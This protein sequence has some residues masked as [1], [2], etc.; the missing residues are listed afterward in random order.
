MNDMSGFP[1]PEQLGFGLYLAP[2]VVSATHDG[3]SWS[4]PA[5]LRRD[6]ARLP[7]CNGAVQYG[8][9]VFEGLKAYRLPD[10]SAALFRPADHAQR[11]AASAPRLALPEV[12]DALFLE[13]C[14]LAV[15]AHDALLPPPGRGSLYLR[16]TICADDETLGL[17]RAE[18]HR[19]TV[20]V[21]PC[22]DP[23]LKTLRLWAE[24]ELIRAAPGGLGAVKTAAN[25]AAGMGGLLRARER[26][27]DDVCWLDAREHRFLGEAGTMNLFVQVGNKLLTP[28]LDGTILAGVTRR[29]ILAL[30]REMG[31]VVEERAI[32]LE[33]LSDGRG[34]EAFGC[35]T[36]ARVV[37]I[38]QIGD[39]QRRLDFAEGPLVPRLAARLKD[40]QEGSTAS[41]AEWRVAV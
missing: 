21:T 25:Y 16:P 26:G 13:S 9:S 14:R 32:P 10:G 29:S 28:P 33:E 3:R 36:A 31:I 17:K 2:N 12:D 34:G 35:G 23:P 22:A 15:R 18:R 4:A 40:A 24:P 20:A 30:A 1:A 19:Y 11:L 37:R 5:V 27:Y 39:E 8:L 7:V 41:H 38:G 6:D